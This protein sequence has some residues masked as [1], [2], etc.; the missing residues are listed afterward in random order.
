MEQ[1]RRSTRMESVTRVVTWPPFAKK[2]KS[3]GGRC[4]DLKR[5]DLAP[6]SLRMMFLNEEGDGRGEWGGGCPG[7]CCEGLGGVK[8]ETEQTERCMVFRRDN[9]RGKSCRMGF[10]TGAVHFMR[11]NRPCDM[12]GGRIRS[13]RQPGKGYFKDVAWAHKYCYN[14]GKTGKMCKCDESFT[15]N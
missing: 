13:N 3:D 2:R 5:Q 10:S 7:A 11:M 9:W 1:T 6:E 4:A 8:T 15:W 14:V 12:K